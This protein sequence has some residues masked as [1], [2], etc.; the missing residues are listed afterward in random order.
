MR[1]HDELHALPRW[2]LFL[3]VIVFF[4]GVAMIAGA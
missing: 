4:L 1:R 2:T 3:A